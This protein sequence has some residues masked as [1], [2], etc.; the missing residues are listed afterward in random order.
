LRERGVIVLD[1]DSG[2]L[3]CGDEGSGRMPDP[4]VIA[5]FVRQ[6]FASRDLEGKSILVTAGPTREPIDPVR[7]VSNRSSGKM[8]YAL[9]EAARR[10]GAS[11]TLISG[12]TAL[13]APV[14]VAISSVTTAA[15]MHA[16]VMDAAPRH[17]I[18]IKAAAV[19]DYA[20]ALM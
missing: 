18:V 7:Y 16:A 10:R 2:L 19:A 17:Q 1:P 20:P 3:A 5:D 4:P 9:A 6:H 15:E 8:G 14:G 12:P 13:A 11:V